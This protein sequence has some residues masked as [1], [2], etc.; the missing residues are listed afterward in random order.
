MARS[1]A[2][3]PEDP[4]R[5][6]QRELSL[7]R[8]RARVPDRQRRAGRLPLRPGVRAATRCGRRPLAEAEDL[9]PHR[10]RLGRGRERTRIGPVR[11]RVRDVVTRAQLRGTLGRRPVRH[12]HRRHDRHAEGRHV[13]QRRH[14]LRPRAGNRR[15]DRRTGARR[16]PARRAGRGQPDAAGVLRHPS[17]DA[18]RGPD[19]D[20]EPVVPR[21][22]AR[23]HP[24]VQPGGRMGRV[25]GPGRELDDHHR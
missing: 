24:A 1:D 7:R 12:L 16:I 17:A 21:E 13:A 15:A 25:R 14:L 20:A 19:R 3:V 9:R 11:G 5:A 6:D 22:H 23:P 4:G 2:R 10:R 8:G 18:R